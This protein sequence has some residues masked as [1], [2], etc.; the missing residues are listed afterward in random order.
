M[1]TWGNQGY[2]KHQGNET[3]KVIQDDE[4]GDTKLENKT[5]ETEDT[6]VKQEVSKTNE[7]PTQKRRLDNNSTGE[8][9]N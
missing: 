9:E 3:H 5:Q 4:T 1:D 8:Q 7:P 6:K 2:G